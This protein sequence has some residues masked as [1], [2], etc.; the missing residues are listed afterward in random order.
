MKTLA[1][2]DLEQF[3]GGEDRYMNFVFCLKFVD[4]AMIDLEQFQGGSL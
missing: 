2:T 3:Q 4:I 1:V